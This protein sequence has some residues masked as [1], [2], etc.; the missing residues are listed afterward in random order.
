MFILPTFN[1]TCNIWRYTLN[2][3]TD[4]P[5][6]AG[7]VCNLQF[8][9]KNSWGPVESFVPNTSHT[10]FNNNIANYAMA[11]NLLLPVHTDIRPAWY[12]G[13]VNVGQGDF[14]EVPAG[15]GRFYGTMDVDD[16]AKGF[17][18][19]YRVA[20][21]V[22]FPTWPVPIEPCHPALAV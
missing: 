7:Q 14:V 2:P 13:V 11:R 15:S 5:T 16:V 10:A 6:I 22:P 1:L 3:R 9:H 8:G 19:E 12:G 18:N 21:L 4:P 17:T 20:L